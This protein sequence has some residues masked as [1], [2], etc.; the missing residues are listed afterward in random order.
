MTVDGLVTVPPTGDLAKGAP[1]KLQMV[2]LLSLYMTL[3]L[4]E[5]KAAQL[6]ASDGLVEITR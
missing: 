5:S 2:T 6:Q 1:G 3:S 4:H